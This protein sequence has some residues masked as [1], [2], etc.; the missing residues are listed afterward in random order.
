MQQM[1]QIGGTEP[2]LFLLVLLFILA[3]FI[4]ARFTLGG[5]FFAFPR[6]KFFRPESRFLFRWL[7]LF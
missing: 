7:L 4:F 2:F 1:Q 6:T 5:C 3:G